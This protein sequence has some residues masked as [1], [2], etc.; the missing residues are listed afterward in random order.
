MAEKYN[1]LYKQPILF[2]RI[3]KHKYYFRT[4]LIEILEV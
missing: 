3:L 1:G 2:V 4:A